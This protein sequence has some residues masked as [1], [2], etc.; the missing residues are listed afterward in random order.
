MVDGVLVPMPAFT[1]CTHGLSNN[2]TKS[3]T[4]KIRSYGLNALEF[5]RWL[6]NIAAE[7]PV[8]IHIHLTILTPYLLAK[9]F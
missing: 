4:S 6:S 8:K 2:L 3:W 9:I 1:K 7:L 5:T